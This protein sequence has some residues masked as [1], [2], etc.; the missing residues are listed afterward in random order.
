MARFIPNTEEQRQEML[1]TVGVSSI[2]SLFAD[3]PES[4][5]LG[6]NLNIPSALSELELSR[7]ISSMAAQNANAQDY[8]C[9]LGAG[10][11][12][13]FIPTVVNHLAGRQ[14]FLTSYTPYQPEV[15]QGTL[16][17]IFEYQ[18]MI[19]ELTGMD[20]ANASM[21]D[22]ATAM[23][24][25]AFMAAASTKRSEVLV[26]RS[27]NP[28]SKKVLETY[29]PYQHIKVTEIGFKNGQLDVDDL[30]KHLSDNIAAVFVQTPNFFGA[31][32]DL[33]GIGEIVKNA[34]ALFAVATD[35]MALS[36]LEPPV[37]FGADAVIGDG[38]PMG[39]AMSFGG[40]GFGFLAVTKK[41]MRKIP[42]R[43]VGQTLDRNGK[44]GYVLTLQAREQHIRREKAT[45]NICS[46][47][48]LNIVMATI[49]M[50]LM[51]KKGLREVA[52]ACLQKAA[53]T[54]DLLIE[55][56]KFKP[57]FDAP[58]F[59]EF[60]VICPETPEALNKRLF[61]QGFIGGYSLSREYPELENSWLVAVTEKRTRD[62][63]DRFARI[64]R[65]E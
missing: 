44:T 1:R 60:A 35:L 23:A 32:E 15:S 50:S 42:G 3:I 28:E 40:P 64:A 4:I 13:H 39:N 27:A 65:G 30:K 31:L 49:Y 63:I 6:K 8:A 10:V 57:L 16:Q 59:R 26:A 41:Y 14:E 2:D 55:D 62:E 48:N 20:V 25:V 18:T 34:G 7:Q 47:H 52:E 58:F 17:T 45:S 46:N 36:L 51:G 12:D 43:V 54:R 33:K 11:Y 19:C 38:Q 37:T 21:Y 5:R 24:E 29:A 61:E 9:F 56:K 53:Y 22:G